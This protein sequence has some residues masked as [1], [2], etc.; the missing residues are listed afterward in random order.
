MPNTIMANNI[1]YPFFLKSI[2]LFLRRKFED[3][4]ALDTAHCSVHNAKNKIPQSAGQCFVTSWLIK[5]YL[6][7]IGFSNSIS[8]CKGALW[9]AGNQ[10]I[11]NH[12]WVEMNYKHQIIIIDLTQDQVT[13][14]KIYV[15][16]KEDSKENGYL[17]NTKVVYRNLENVK[18]EA[19]LRVNILRER[20]GVI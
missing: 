13:S 14:Y 3:A 4:W 5:E 20:I 12:C 19:R 1:N 18:M 16:S 2:L 8:V 7:K 11:D 9:Y 15:S 6:E 17:Y 10:I